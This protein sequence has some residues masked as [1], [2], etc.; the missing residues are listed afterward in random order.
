MSAERDALVESLLVERFGPITRL[1]NEKSHDLYAE[2]RNVIAA[3][4]PDEAAEDD[5]EEVE[6]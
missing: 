5:D 6:E 2:R 4:V 1:L 3:E